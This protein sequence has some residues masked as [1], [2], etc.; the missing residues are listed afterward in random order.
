MIIDDDKVQAAL[1]YLN[2]DPHPLALA[3]KDL[4]D[5]EIE[6][7]RVYAILFLGSKGNIRE[8][9]C[10]AEACTEYVDTAKLVAE[11]IFKVEN[12]K[13]RQVGAQMLLEC[14]RTEQSNIRALEKIR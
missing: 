1:D 8:R 2:A 3:R 14:W 11:A 13:A 10:Q 7:D 12:E 4:A 9:E 6:R 5:A